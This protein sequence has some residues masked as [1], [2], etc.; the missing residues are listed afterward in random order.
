MTLKHPRLGFHLFVYD[1]YLYVVGGWRRGP[2]SQISYE[3]RQ[4]VSDTTYIMDSGYINVNSDDLITM[5]VKEIERIKV[6]GNGNS[7]ISSKTFA[8]ELASSRTMDF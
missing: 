1:E 6:R 3:D 8:K 7:I 4:N 5:T 2:K